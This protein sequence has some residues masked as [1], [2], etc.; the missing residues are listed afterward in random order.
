MVNV[1]TR[2]ARSA[3]L[4]NWLAIQHMAV[5]TI[6]VVEEPDDLHFMAISHGRNQL[7]SSSPGTVDEPP[8]GEMRA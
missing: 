3:G 8:W 4:V 1:E 2:L 7:P 6:I 5:Q